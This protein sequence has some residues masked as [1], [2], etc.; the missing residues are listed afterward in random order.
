M[1]SSCLGEKSVWG[2]HREQKGPWAHCRSLRILPPD[3]RAASPDRKPDPC[4]L[5]VASRSAVQSSNQQGK[6]NWE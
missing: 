4:E 2:V 5:W 3:P 1:T 6:C